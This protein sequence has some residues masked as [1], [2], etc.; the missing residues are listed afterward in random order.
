MI[1]IIHM[2]FFS[3]KQFMKV[4]YFV[5]LLI[6]TTISAAIIQVLGS[7]TFENSVS[8]INYLRAALIGMWTTTTCAAGLSGFE[9]ARSTLCYLYIMSSNEYITIMCTVSSASL[10]GLF[11]LP[12]AF[13][14]YLIISFF[15]GLLY[16]PVA[17]SSL[18]SAIPLFLLSWVS[19]LT[20]S[21]FVASIFVLTPN[22]ISYEGLLLLPMLLISG[23]ATPI[24]VS[25]VLDSII[26]FFNPLYFPTNVL[27]YAKTVSSFSVVLYIMGL[28][29]WL[30]LAYLA[31]KFA[32]KK[33]RKD[34]TLELM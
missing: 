12:L 13:V 21:L 8:P 15:S 33:A 2:S 18:L 9:R 14:T 31:C 1:R 20:I 11:A 29:L 23:I 17:L 16:L 4:D 6:A 24:T 30:I 7:I 28:F 32:F 22:A 34:A 19:A 27:L 26:C 25:P 5:K 3:L 10:F